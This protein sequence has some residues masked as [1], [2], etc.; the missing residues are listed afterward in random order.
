MA[1]SQPPKGRTI[2]SGA[3]KGSA[4]MAAAFEAMRDG[5]PEGLVVAPYGYP[6]GHVRNLGVATEA[7]RS[8]PA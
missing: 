4:G 2:V 5:L 3:G 6:G 7:D 8:R 1:A